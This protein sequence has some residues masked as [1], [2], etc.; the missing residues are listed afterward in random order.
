MSEEIASELGTYRN[1][2]TSV[3]FTLTLNL[4]Q[5][6]T[7]VNDKVIPTFINIY[8]NTKFHPY[9]KKNMWMN[10]RI[11]NLNLLGHFGEMTKKGKLGHTL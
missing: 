11:S 10:G 2:E 1:F 6:H 9:Q 5:G 3:T 8:P 4:G 7:I